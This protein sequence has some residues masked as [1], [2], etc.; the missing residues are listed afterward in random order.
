MST[1]V[2]EYDAKLDS[3]KRLTIRGAKA[4]FYHVSEKED[5]TIELSPRQL[6]HPYQISEKTLQM[7]DK[8]VDKFKKG[9]ASA[10]VDL[11]ELDRLL[12]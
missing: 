8:A 7:M 9:E 6:A 12:D 1:V 5:G 11:E 4:P 10:P 2:K 3:K